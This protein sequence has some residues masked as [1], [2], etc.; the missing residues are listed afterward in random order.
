LSTP[1]ST[2]PSLSEL[3]KKSSSTSTSTVDALSSPPS[4]TSRLSDLLKKYRLDQNS[5]PST[6]TGNDLSK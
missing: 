2:T 6:S 4:S 1:P 5:A 3:L